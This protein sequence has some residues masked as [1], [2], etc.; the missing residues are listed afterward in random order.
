MRIM[1]IND[2]MKE[3]LGKLELSTGLNPLFGTS[4]EM[5]V[6]SDKKPSEF[7]DFKIFYPS[8]SC[9]RLSQNMGLPY[10][11]KIDRVF[12]KDITLKAICTI[13]NEVEE[14]LKVLIDN[15]DNDGFVVFAARD[16]GGITET[17]WKFDL[18]S[19]ELS[20]KIVHAYQDIMGISDTSI[21]LNFLQS[22]QPNVMKQVYKPHRYDRA[23]DDLYTE[24]ELLNVSLPVRIFPS[25]IDLFLS[26]AGIYKSVLKKIG[27]EDKCEYHIKPL[28][29][30]KI[31]IS[32]FSKYI[33][34]VSP[35]ELD[36]IFWMLLFIKFYIL[37]GITKNPDNMPSVENMKKITRILVSIILVFKNEVLIK[38]E[39]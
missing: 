32:I 34:T 37:C 4:N 31:I 25:C 23:L 11:E 13:M 26:R 20:K 12:D 15:M 29:V 36:K 9:N 17:K 14:D 22:K 19:I 7:K 18:D 28:I 39:K 3:N 8:P 27:E 21:L 5:G 33:R 38:K 35:G 16:V 2:E 24:C 10:G 6:I 30:G 1:K